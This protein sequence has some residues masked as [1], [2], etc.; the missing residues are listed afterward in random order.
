MDVEKLSANEI[1]FFVSHSIP[2]ESKPVYKQLFFTL[3]FCTLLYNKPG[4]P[5]ISGDFREQFCLGDFPI[6][7]KYYIPTPTAT[8]QMWSEMGIK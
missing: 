8:I 2:Q 7:V 6:V 4:M 5:Q 3:N 1:L